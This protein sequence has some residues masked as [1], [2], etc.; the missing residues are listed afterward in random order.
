[1]GE[2]ISDRVGLIHTLATRSPHP[3]SVPI[4]L[5]IPVKKTPLETQAFLSIWEMVR[6]VA[7]ARITMPKAMV[8]LS[9]GRLERSFEETGT[10]LF[11]GSQLRFLRRKTP[12]TAQSYL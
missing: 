5:L 12:H 2:S 6:M 9:A 4:N 3:E 1:M 11:G 7:I 10:L 8:R